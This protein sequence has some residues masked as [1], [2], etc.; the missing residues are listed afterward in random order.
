[1]KPVSWT[2]ADIASLAGRRVLVVGDLIFDRYVRGRSDR[3]SPEA[4]VLV[5]EYES[6]QALLGGAGNV[7][8]NVHAAGARAIPIG[9][10]G[11]DPAGERTREMFREMGVPTGGILSD[12]S[13]PTVEKTRVMAGGQQ[14]VRIDREQR[15][16]IDERLRARVLARIERNAAKCSGV[17]LS[18][19]AKGGLP[20]A[21]VADIV[22]LCRR[23]DLML[24]ADPK[25]DD[26]RRYKGVDYITP[27]Q[28]E[29]QAASGVA[30]EDEASLG[31]AG[32]ALLRVTRG[33]GVVVTRGHEGS[34]LIRRRGM[35]F[36]AP[37]HPREVYDVAGAG[38]SFISYFALALFAGFAPEKAVALGNLAGGLVVGKIGVVP[39]SRDEI[40]RE[41]DTIAQE[42]DGARD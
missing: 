14:I 24:V 31:R 15:R 3:V 28:R 12:S 19:Y 8:H 2:A 10:V 41:L 21:L 36:L 13:R 42:T 18:D 35:A 30:I 17:I 5:L 26:Y 23:H 33:Q 34:L 29:T 6:E 40:E 27:N 9:V 4:P 32:R 20:P 7:A 16:D 11:R 39:V 25:G 1:M 38:D 22:A 37:A